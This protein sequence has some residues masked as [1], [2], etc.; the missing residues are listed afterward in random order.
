MRACFRGAPLFVAS[1]WAKLSDQSTESVPNTRAASAIPA[2][3]GW[4]QLMADSF[5]KLHEAGQLVVTSAGN[6]ETLRVPARQPG[7]PSVN[8]IQGCVCTSSRVAA[9]GAAALSHPLLPQACSTTT[10]RGRIPTV[11]AG[12]S[13]WTT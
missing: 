4:D 9:D 5:I 3:F 10:L 11:S 13:T 2:G 1:R 8:P 6:S 7:G 12:A